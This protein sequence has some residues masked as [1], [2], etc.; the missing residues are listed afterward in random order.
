MPQNFIVINT[1]LETNTI[2]VFSNKFNQNIQLV[3]EQLNED[4]LA[5]AINKVLSA[6]QIKLTEL[7]FIGVVTG[8]GS[9]TKLRIGIA[10]ANALSLGLNIPVISMSLFELLL[11]IV[12]NSNSDTVNY[13]IGINNNKDGVFAEIF[14]GHGK[15]IVPPCEF[16]MADIDG[17]FDNNKKL[18]IVGDGDFIRQKI[19]TPNQNLEYLTKSVKLNTNEV[20]NAFY[21]KY[22]L[23]SVEKMTPA[24]AL[25]IKD[26]RITKA[27]KGN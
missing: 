12:K 18:L 27:N 25:Y 10:T 13:F 11:S 23:T 1:A 8:P 26:P 6:Q 22:E 14:D 24:A 4:T 9:Y 7:N 5:Y 3:Y 15:V 16:N 2:Y 17:Y 20:Y 21:N 19:V